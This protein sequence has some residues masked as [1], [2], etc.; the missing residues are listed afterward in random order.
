ME[1][2]PESIR[3]VFVP[4]GHID[5][6]IQ[7]DFNLKDYRLK[8]ILDCW[9][10]CEADFDINIYIDEII[11]K[12]AIIGASNTEK[13]NNLKI[14]LRQ[15]WAKNPILLRSEILFFKDIR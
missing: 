8:N 14:F 9:K 12:E 5:P 13:I 3:I 7:R 11:Q 2:A 6:T 4:K 15:H 10:P 1:K